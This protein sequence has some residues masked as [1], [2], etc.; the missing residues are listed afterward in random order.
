M[1]PGQSRCW[2]VG[3]LLDG[4]TS[5]QLRVGSDDMRS[6]VAYRADVG[7]I[8][9][10]TSVGSEKRCRGPRS[11]ATA[12]GLRSWIWRKRLLVSCSRGDPSPWD[13]SAHCSYR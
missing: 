1:P 7:S 9:E 5:T 2:L 11:S 8:R 6:L 3:L 12:A 13:S 4:T 10:E